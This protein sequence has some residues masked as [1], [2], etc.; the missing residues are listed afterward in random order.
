MAST[1]SLSSS[2]V[3]GLRL[4][5]LISH[6]MV[7][8]QSADVALW[9]RALPGGSV[10]VA[11][12][13]PCDPLVVPVASDGRWQVTLHTPP[14]SYTPLSL[15]FTSSEGEVVE[16]N[17]I[18]SGEVWLCTGQSNMVMPM[19]GLDGVPVQGFRDEVE[20]AAEL[21]EIRFLT[22][23][24][25]MRSWP[26]DDAPCRWEKVDP[27]TLPH[28]SAV[29][30][31][32]AKRIALTKRVP[33]GM[34]VAAAGGTRVESWLN[35][36]NLQRYTDEPTDPHT[37]VKQY[38]VNYLRPLL[39]GNG[40][41]HPVVPYTVKGMLFYQG[42]SNVGDPA[43]RYSHRLA[44]LVDQWRQALNNPAMPFFFVEIAPYKYEDNVQGIAGA[45]LR[46]EQHKAAR[47][48]PGAAIVC[49]NDLVPPH[50]CGEWHPTRKREVG[51]RLALHALRRLY[52]MPAVQGESA[53]FRSMTVEADTCYIQF[54]NTYGSL[55]PRVGMVGFEIAGADGVFHPA[56]AAPVPGKGVAVCSPLVEEPVAVRYCFR[57][58]RPGNVTNA[59]GLPLF[60]FRTDE[61]E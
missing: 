26:Q 47:R 30:Y 3:T 48:I 6:G 46:E 42:F 57:N 16:V 4:P 52:G 60:P 58:Y 37:I 31:F 49:T 38:P 8:Q 50:E 59:A 9:G 39:W 13:W 28:C 56:E 22:M 27:D 40:T 20:H 36:E 15:R 55:S 54:D 24:Q 35:A 45:L 53:S 1:T 44:L 11:P 61:E 29:A 19:E 51:E 5:Q 2:S 7:L 23:P 14:A 12:S 25:R 32:F 41:F 10:E 34:I 33:M 43:G 21:P 18:L 17:N